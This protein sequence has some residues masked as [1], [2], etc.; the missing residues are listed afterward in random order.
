MGNQSSIF[1]PSLVQRHRS[2]DL[3]QEETTAADVLKK[4][5]VASFMSKLSRYTSLNSNQK[6]GAQSKK[7][8]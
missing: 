5:S 7:K 8:S 1:E 4:R 2:L 6:G 3:E